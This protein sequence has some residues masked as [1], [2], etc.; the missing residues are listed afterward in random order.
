[1]AQEN[2]TVLFRPVG[3]KELELIRDSGYRAFPRRLWHQ[4]I[5][6]PVLTEEYAAKI[7]RQWNASD[8]DSGYVGYVTRFH[9]RSSYLSRH[10]VHDVGGRML[11]EYWIP[12][13]DLPEFNANI[14]GLIEVIGE[15]GDKTPDR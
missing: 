1:M 10:E 4:P 7:A 15:Y 11:Q 9:V 14:V 6:Y 12:A 3:Q 5:F 13:D 8:P 2:T